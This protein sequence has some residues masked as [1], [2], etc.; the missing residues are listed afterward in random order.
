M[1]A[2]SFSLTKLVFTLSK[3]LIKLLK[4]QSALELPSVLTSLHSSSFAD[5]SS[6][7]LKLPTAKTIF[8]TQLATIAASANQSLFVHQLFH[9]IRDRLWRTANPRLRLVN[10]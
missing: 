9:T 3:A 1:L 5:C 6:H 4:I 10:D 8:P 7:R 2:S